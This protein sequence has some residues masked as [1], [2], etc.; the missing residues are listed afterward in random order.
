MGPTNG[1]KG[2]TEIWVPL[3]QLT[4]STNRNHDNDLT[5]PNPNCPKQQKV[6]INYTTMQM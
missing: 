4:L 6:R 1:K 5:L 2:N 3:I